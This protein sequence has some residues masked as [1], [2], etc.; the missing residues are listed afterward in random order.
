MS[1]P[2]GT[3]QPAVGQANET[4]CKRCEPGS[5]GPRPGLASCFTCPSGSYASDFGS[6]GCTICPAGT[7]TFSSGALRAS[8]CTPCRGSLS[9]LGGASVRISLHFMGLDFGAIGA[10]LLSVLSAELARDLSD[11]IG[12]PVVD[13]FDQANSSTL[14]SGRAAG[15]PGVKVSVFA[16]VPEGSSANV[17]AK[18]LYTSS[19]QSHVVTTAEGVL[20][21]AGKQNAILGQLSAPVVA[22]KPERFVPREHTTITT[23]STMTTTST[24]TTRNLRS[25]TTSTAGSSDEG[26]TTGAYHHDVSTTSKDGV[27]S[28]VSGVSP[29]GVHFAGL[30]ALMFC[31]L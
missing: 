7:W 30:V 10:D 25:Q 16:T 14:E 4:L 28:P 19:F 15:I 26:R 27:S 6:N 22:V 21:R 31:F 3:Y 18:E 29:V 9:C 20:E 1:C 11:T 8:D 23:T 2:A 24:S 5:F 13:L 12:V 17:M